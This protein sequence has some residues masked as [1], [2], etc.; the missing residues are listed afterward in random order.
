MTVVTSIFCFGCDSLHGDRRLREASSKLNYKIMPEVL[1]EIADVIGVDKMRELLTA[2][3]GTEIYIPSKITDPN[4][5]LIDLLGATAAHALVDYYRVGSATGTFVGKEILLPKFDWAR[6]GRYVEKMWLEQEA[7][8]LTSA[9]I[10]RMLGV[11]RR[12][13]CRWRRK[14]RIEDAA[15]R[16]AEP[17]AIAE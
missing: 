1:E 14:K 10:A 13:V 11:H 2:R 16:P 8:G 4:H 17:K 6:R 15:N 5:W 3:S 9:R 7:R 12:T